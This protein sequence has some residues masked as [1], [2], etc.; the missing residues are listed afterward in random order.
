MNTIYTL[1]FLAGKIF[2]TFRMKITASDLK[3][4]PHG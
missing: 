3:I 2:K 4:M 1:Q